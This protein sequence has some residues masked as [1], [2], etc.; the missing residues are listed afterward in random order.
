MYVCICAA[1]PP[2][3]AWCPAP[4]PPTP[5]P[6]PPRPPPLPPPPAGRRDGPDGLPWMT[7]PAASARPLAPAA[8]MS[9]WQPVENLGRDRLIAKGINTRSPPAPN[10]PIFAAKHARAQ[11]AGWHGCA[12]PRPLPI[13]E[14]STVRR[15]RTYR[16]EG[17]RFRPCPSLRPDA[18]QSSRNRPACS[19]RPRVRSAP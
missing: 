11:P 10:P 13:S 9:P 2:S 12:P 4:M 16:A 7:R 3:S 18:V 14:V 5:P 17:R 6:L 8:P 15:S 1:P 19:R